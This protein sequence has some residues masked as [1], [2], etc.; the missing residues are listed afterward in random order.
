V[1]VGGRLPWAIREE[2]FMGIADYSYILSIAPSLC[3]R[4]VI[5]AYLDIGGGHERAHCANKVVAV[6]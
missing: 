3:F 4:I 5:F 2:E 1:V 6:I